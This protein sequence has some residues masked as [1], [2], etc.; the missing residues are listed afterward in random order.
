MAT[1][2]LLNEKV[3]RQQA[4]AL[5]EAK[6]ARIEAE[7]VRAASEAAEQQRQEITTTA[8]EDEAARASA[9][10]ASAA[11]GGG[12]AAKRWAVQAKGSE[13]GAANVVEV[14][15]RAEVL[16]ASEIPCQ[17]PKIV[18]PMKNPVAV[19]RPNEKAITSTTEPTIA[20]DEGEATDATPKETK[21][22]AAAL[23]TL[24][25]WPPNHHR[26]MPEAEANNGVDGDGGMGGKGGGDGGMGGKGGGDGGMGGKG[27]G[28]S[29]DGVADNSLRPPRRRSVRERGSEASKARKVSRNDP[30][31]TPRRRSKPMNLG[32]SGADGEGGEEGKATNGVG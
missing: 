7:A 16:A 4:Q 15:V 3:A 6:A 18:Q 24:P 11:R 26:S 12:V 23:Y 17:T 19:A 1:L 28:D 22:D 20:K 32:V 5:L 31:R 9:A 29:R 8:V 30:L 21:E 2:R 27:G 14:E 13:E 10:A 25:C